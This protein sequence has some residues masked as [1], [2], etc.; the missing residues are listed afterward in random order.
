MRRKFFLVSKLRKR[1]REQS[2]NM[3]ADDQGDKIQ[4]DE[5][6]RKQNPVALGKLNKEGMD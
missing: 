1:K 4:S 3:R 6:T 5:S 2:L